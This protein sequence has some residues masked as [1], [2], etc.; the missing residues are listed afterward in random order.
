MRLRNG[1][2]WPRR[3]CFPGLRV[4]PRRDSDFR[5]HPIQE[6]PACLIHLKFSLNDAVHGVHRI[7]RALIAKET[8][9]RQKAVMA[10]GVMTASPE[11]HGQ[12]RRRHRHED[13]PRSGG[14]SNEA[15][16]SGKASWMAPAVTGS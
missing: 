1:R 16:Y 5:R 9:K 3:S 6:A 14:G 13:Q 15:T 8:V 2:E 7:Q 11:S 10:I 12:N 4:R